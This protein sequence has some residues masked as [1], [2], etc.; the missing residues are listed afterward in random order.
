MAAH[1][2]IGALQGV[3]VFAYVLIFG[4]MWRLAAALLADSRVGQA[5]SWLY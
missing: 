3:I 4:F 1:V 5:M 2:H